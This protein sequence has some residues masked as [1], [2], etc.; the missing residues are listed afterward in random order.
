MIDSSAFLSVHRAAADI[1][2]ICG[3]QGMD[4]HREAEHLAEELVPQHNFRLDAASLEGKHY[5]EVACR[6][7]RESV[8]AVM[9]HRCQPSGM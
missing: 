4:F 6:D 2:P 9:P 8:L 3:A 5:G 7:F 1:L